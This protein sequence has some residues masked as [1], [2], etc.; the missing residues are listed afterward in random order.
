MGIKVEW[1][2]LNDL[3][4]IVEGQKSSFYECYQRYQDHEMSPYNVTY[5][6]MKGIFESEYLYKILYEG[7]LVGAIYVQENPDKYNM[8]L[9]GIFIIPEYQ[10]KGIGQKA[11]EYVEGL[12]DEATTWVLETPHDL[13]RNHHVYEKMGYVRTGEEDAVNENLTIIH[14]KKE[15]KRGVM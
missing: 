3:E 6:M 9:H 11:I 7:K 8:K 1:A 5:E 15:I 14:Y 2:E 4:L 13:K 10:D 12:H